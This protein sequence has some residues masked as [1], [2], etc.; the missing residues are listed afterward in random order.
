M[1]KIGITMRV[2]EA[3]GY[4]E[5]RDALAQDWTDFMA[6]AFPECLWMPVPNVGNRVVEYVRAWDLDAFI[7]SG[8]N[9]LG[10]SP[11]RDQ[12]EQALLKYA[13]EN[14]LPVF[15]V[16]RGLQ[17]LHQYYGGA[18]E[19]CDAGVHVAA[20]H[21]VDLNGETYRVNS[22]HNFGIRETA[23]SPALTVIARTGDGWVEGVDLTDAPGRAVMWHPERDRPYRKRDIQLMRE[24]LLEGVPS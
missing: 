2:V 16:C 8:G 14:R 11:R 1:I 13:V 17:L 23:V 18:L 7:F 21:D 4:R 22:Y 24:C 6:V 3:Q 10:S 15:G 9:D 12:T 5:P 20:Q 19:P